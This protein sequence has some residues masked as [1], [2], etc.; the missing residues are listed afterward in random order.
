MFLAAVL[1]SLLPCSEECEICASDRTITDD[2]P[3]PP[4]L[5][6]FAARKTDPKAVPALDKDRRRSIIVGVVSEARGGRD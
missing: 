4:A 2:A 1:V 5:E 6:R 3:Q